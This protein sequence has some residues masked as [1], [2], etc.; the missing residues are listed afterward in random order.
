MKDIQTHG[1]EII[2]IIDACPEGISATALADRVERDFGTGTRF[3]TCSAEDMSLDELLRFLVERDKIQ[4][5]N[6]LIFSG[7]SPACSHD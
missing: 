2:A 4:Y 1:H 5:R 6:G 3:F 7:A